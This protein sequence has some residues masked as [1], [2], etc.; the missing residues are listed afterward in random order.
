MHL[1]HGLGRGRGFCERISQ[2]TGLRHSET[3]ARISR[4]RSPRLS[5]LHS[6]STLISVID[7]GPSDTVAAFDFLRVE[8]F[9]QEQ[10]AG[11]SSLLSV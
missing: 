4:S 3:E 10:K 2:E 1:F 11:V 6:I 5:S 9:P 7:E 8:R